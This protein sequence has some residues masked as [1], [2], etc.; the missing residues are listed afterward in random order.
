MS[1]SALAYKQASL[2]M[3]V[4]CPSTNTSV[5]KARGRVLENNNNNNSKKQQNN[6]NNN[7]RWNTLGLCGS[8]CEFELVWRCLL[9]CLSGRSYLSSGE[10]SISAQSIVDSAANHSD[11]TKYWGPVHNRRAHVK[12]STAVV[13]NCFGKQA[14][15]W[16]YQR[17][18][19]ISRLGSVTLRRLVIPKEATGVSPG[20][21]SKWH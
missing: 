2:D 10:R 20:T 15:K 19:R 21:Y 14:W 7:K 12:D 4:G 5:H 18:E 6:N 16:L 3:P 1:Q 8:N 11:K 9:R 17:F 13:E